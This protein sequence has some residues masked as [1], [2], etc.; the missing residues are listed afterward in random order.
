MQIGGWDSELTGMYVAKF[1]AGFPEGNN[2]TTSV[3]SSQNYT[4]DT[5][6]VSKIENGSSQDIGNT[7]RNWLDGIYGEIETKISYPVFQPLTYGMNYI[8]HND[9]YNICKVMNENGNIYG[10]TVSSS[11]THLMKNSEWG[12]VS[13]LSYSKYGT[14]G[15]KIA[16]NNA[17]LNSGGQTRTVSTGKN[18]VDSVYAITGMTQGLTDGE[19]TV[20]KIDEIKALQGNTPT[21]TGS[22][23]AWNQKGG[24]TASSTRNMTGVYDLSGGLFERIAAYVPNESVNLKLYGESIA[25][26]EEAL[27]TV[28]TKYTTVY[29][30]DSSV[31]NSTK[32]EN[33]ENIDI[34]SSGN[35]LKNTSIYG[36]GVRETSTSGVGSTSWENNASYYVGLFNPFVFR[37]GPYS[38]SIHAGRFYSDRDDGFSGYNVG[39]RAIVIP[40]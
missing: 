10:F 32:E 9:A 27:K 5:A 14:N 1:E 40:K 31:D 6:W 29:P 3:K 39:F 11:D 18:G 23:Y 38:E 25:Y 17:N 36:D 20:V 12:M 15:Q 28:S 35:Y 24:I 4:Q 7:A 8:N 37:G 30:Y 33:V 13:Y 22:M 2:N 21:T 19:E 16:V 34:A 26:N